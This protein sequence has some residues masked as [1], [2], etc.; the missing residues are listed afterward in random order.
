MFP[1]IGVP[2]NGW[3]I[4]ENPIKT[5]DLGGFPPYFWKHLI[6]WAFITICSRKKCFPAQELTCQERTVGL[7]VLDI[8]RY[9]VASTGVHLPRQPVARATWVWFLF[10]H[11][12]VVHGVSSIICIH[13]QTND[14]P[15]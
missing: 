12:T 14:Y 9:G 11:R 3:F 13:F 7:D 15:P 2:Q 6:Y 4:M 1:K 8:V 10:I 5:D